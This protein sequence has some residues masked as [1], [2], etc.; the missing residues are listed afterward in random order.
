MAWA[1]RLWARQPEMFHCKICKETHFLRRNAA[2]T[3]NLDTP[4]IWSEEGEKYGGILI[5]RNGHEVGTWRE[6]HGAN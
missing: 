6:Q 1:Y 5:C 3:A 2:N 4:G